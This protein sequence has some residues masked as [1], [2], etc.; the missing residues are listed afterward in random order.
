MRRPALIL[1]C[2]ILC[3]AFGR[4]ASAQLLFPI[5]A[6]NIQLSTSSILEQ[7]ANIPDYSVDRPS[8]PG[9]TEADVVD[10]EEGE[11]ADTDI[12][13]SSALSH[14]PEPVNLGGN[15]SL[16]ITRHD[17]GEKINAH[18]RNKDGSYNPEELA[19]INHIM[20]CSLTGEETEISIKLVE[21]L[22]AMED[23][24]GKRGI[25]LLSGYRTPKLNSKTPGAAKHSMHMLGWAAD[26]RIPGYSSTKV[27]RAGI[28]MGIGGVGYY[29]Y[30]GFTHLDVGNARY[31]V[32]SRPV[33][34]HRRRS[35]YRETQ[36]RRTAA[37]RRRS[38]PVRTVSRQKAAKRKSA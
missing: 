24:F 15:G 17:T 1:L 3:L 30:K 31:W 12:F 5:V 10:L 28:K 8:V 19:K 20:R 36:N 26:I 34:R 23:K 37:A 38:V 32:V 21:L 9:V 16:T 13:I 14:P 29:P 6:S 35:P 4:P 22:D 2:P 7:L 11:E 25:T 33:H 27:K 18:Y